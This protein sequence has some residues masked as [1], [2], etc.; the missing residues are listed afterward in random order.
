MQDL[1]ATTRH[2]VTRKK[3]TKRLKHKAKLFR[4]SVQVKSVLCLDLKPFRS[5]L[6]GKHSTCREFQSLAA[7]R[8]KLDR[9]IG[10]LPSGHNDVAKTL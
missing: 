10:I 2:G 9:D 7:R 4:K 6:N 3:C 5:W 1:T 8:K